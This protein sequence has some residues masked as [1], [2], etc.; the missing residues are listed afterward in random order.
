[1]FVLSYCVL[2]GVWNFPMVDRGADS[3]ADTSLFRNRAQEREQYEGCQ[4]L[5]IWLTGPSNVVAIEVHVTGLV[6]TG[7][8]N[9]GWGSVTA[10]H[11]KQCD[12]TLTSELRQAEV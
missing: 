11:A 3:D 4:H 9:L 8:D 10:R 12:G 7:V 6:A 2:F 5:E 1:M